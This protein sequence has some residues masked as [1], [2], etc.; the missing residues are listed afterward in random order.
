[1]TPGV[2][3][4]VFHARIVGSK[5]V[6]EQGSASNAAAIYKRFLQNRRNVFAKVVG[7]PAKRTQY[8]VGNVVQKSRMR[9]K[10]K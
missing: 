5:Q 3:M 1:M 10:L 6:P 4:M 9:K 7:L 2:V 8:I